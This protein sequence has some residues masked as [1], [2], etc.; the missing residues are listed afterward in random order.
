MS[1]TRFRYHEGHAMPTSSR[2]T[3]S[4]LYGTNKIDRAPTANSHFLPQKSTLSVAQPSSMPR[5]NLGSRS[6]LA[7]GTEETPGPGHY[8]TVKSSF[9]PPSSGVSIKGGA[10][11]AP[12]RDTTT[13]PQKL[14]EDANN[15]AGHYEKLTTFGEAKKQ[16]GVIPRASRTI[17]W[18][19]K[20]DQ[21][22]TTAQFYAPPSTL[23]FRG[24]AHL[25]SR[26]P[27]FFPGGT[28]ATPGPAAYSPRNPMQSSDMKRGIRIA[29]AKRKSA[30]SGPRAAATMLEATPGP[31][32]YAPETHY[33]HARKRA[34]ARN[35][36]KGG[37]LSARSVMSGTSQMSS[38]GPPSHV[39][40][41][42]TS[43]DSSKK[44]AFAPAAR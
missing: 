31:G 23:D 5:A 17:S 12:I 16:G 19:K 43:R 37:L 18:M 35:K 8:S 22:S 11:R 3:N 26:S 28:D 1:W 36:A 38:R 41:S 4:W 14:K 2:D 30:P 6:K 27:R 9:K 15:P 25:G 32:A 29:Q 13:W 42:S 20:R 24:A 10:K 7:P 40:T 39:P 21:A 34:I 44:Y 33:D